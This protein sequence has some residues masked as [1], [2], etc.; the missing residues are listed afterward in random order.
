MQH[1]RTGTVLAQLLSAISRF[2]NVMTRFARVWFGWG[3]R[4][5]LG[6]EFRD[7]SNTI[8]KRHRTVAKGLVDDRI[9]DIREIFSISLTANA[10]MKLAFCQKSW[11]LYL[12]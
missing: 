6:P 2:V 5:G 11:K 7:L 4:L 8:A 1:H 3:L 12:I 10:T 9:V